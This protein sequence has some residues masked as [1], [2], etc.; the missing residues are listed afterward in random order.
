MKQKIPVGALAATGTVGQ[1]L[2]QLL[3][4]HPWFEL[5]LVT[6]SERSAGRPYGEAVNWKLVGDLPAHVA[7]LLVQPTTAPLS[8][9]LLFSAFPIAEAKT[10]EPLLAKTGHIVL[11]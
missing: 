4:N 5:R 7:N 2:V 6:G 3:A 1:R 10:L 11:T 8:A 9:Q